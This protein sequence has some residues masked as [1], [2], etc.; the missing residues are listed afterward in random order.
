MG[1]GSGV[2][3]DA[4]EQELHLHFRGQATLSLG[5]AISPTIGS[6]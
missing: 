1:T 3:W 5:I 6:D 4:S 2:T